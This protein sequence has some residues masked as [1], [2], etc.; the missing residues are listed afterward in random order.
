ME[1]KCKKLMLTVASVLLC[2]ISHCAME[3]QTT[4]MQHDIRLS[5]LLL[6]TAAAAG[7]MI[8]AIFW[9]KSFIYLFLK[10]GMADFLNILALFNGQN[11][12]H[13]VVT[14]IEVGFMCCASMVLA[15]RVITGNH[16]S[17]KIHFIGLIM[18]INAALNSFLIQWRTATTD[19]HVSHVSLMLS[20]IV[21]FCDVVEIAGLWLVHSSCRKDVCSQPQDKDFGFTEIQTDMPSNSSLEEDGN[22]S[23]FL[24]LLKDFI[25]DV[26]GIIHIIHKL[27]ENIKWTDLLSLSWHK[28][29]KFKDLKFRLQY[30]HQIMF[31][32]PSKS[33]IILSN[34]EADNILQ[35]VH[36]KKGQTILLRVVNKRSHQT[37]LT[38][39]YSSY[40]VTSPDPSQPKNRNH[41]EKQLCLD[42]HA[43]I[44]EIHK[45]CSTP[46]DLDFQMF[47]N[48]SPCKQCS[49][50]LK[51][52]LQELT[53][54]IF[55][56]SVEI[57]VRY[58]WPYGKTKDKK[59]LK[60]M[61][62]HSQNS[63]NIVSISD[64]SWVQFYDAF[65]HYI[66]M[67][68]KGTALS[69]AKMPH[70]LYNDQDKSKIIVKYLLQITQD[71]LVDLTLKTTEETRDWNA[72]NICH[73]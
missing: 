46:T 2:F 54:D 5:W 31:V 60:K 57:S 43:L 68:D 3:M 52:L 25:S 59:G 36:A 71:R 30:L 70:F 53:E 69:T 11:S 62:N 65:C 42:K 38:K 4:F 67:H 6:C 16:K 9:R 45:K 47:M 23:L 64:F 14:I 34:E 20:Y 18:V 41:A 63:K 28:Y 61:I 35:I 8:Y 27:P 39:M 50:D 48:N 51:N 33:E 72:K 44:D 49:R 37:I 19:A 29:S 26:A 56:E 40:A 12:Y 1:K 10:P 17:E 24:D 13:F 73:T 66:A 22:L 58:N 32:E 21:F 55:N 7:L 15:I